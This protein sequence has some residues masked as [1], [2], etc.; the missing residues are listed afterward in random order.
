MPVI[1]ISKKE[2]SSYKFKNLT[3]FLH[4]KNKGLIPFC[5]PELHKIVPNFP[6]VF[7]K[8]EKTVTLCFLAS[9]IPNNNLFIDQKGKWLGTYV[10]AV[11]RSVPLGFFS[12]KKNEDKV[13]C[14]VDEFGCVL[15][16][17]TCGNEFHYIFEKDGEFTDP[18]KKKVQF[19]HAYSEGT[20]ETQ[21]LCNK[22]NEE[23]LICE[24]PLKLKSKDGENEI[25][26]L[27]K[28]DEKKLLSLN[29]KTIKKF[30][31]SKLLDI[32]FGQI[33]S[34]GNLDKI[35]QKHSQIYSDDAS[36][37]KTKSLRDQVLEKQQKE[38]DAEVDAL[39]KNLIT[40]E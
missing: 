27:F 9:F 1:P 20:S 33:F 29:E 24:W 22:L 18:F 31:D 30:L 3:H 4:F 15:P 6:I 16:E 14:Y 26:G 40:N 25:K 23:G 12:P 37:K 28:I 34:M 39:V 2:H 36:I 13:L 38:S 10:P 19:A 11:F 35:A 17:D 5:M 8:K 21:K 7:T 32:A